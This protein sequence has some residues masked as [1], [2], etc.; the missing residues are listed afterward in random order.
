MVNANS[1]LAQPVKLDVEPKINEEATIIKQYEN[2]ISELE[3]AL[4]E[5]QKIINELKN[6]I[7]NMNQN[8]NVN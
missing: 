8:Q 2:K 3:K 6:I 4:L 7:Y 1:E 5:Q